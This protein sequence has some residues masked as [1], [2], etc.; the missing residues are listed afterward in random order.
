MHF[1][2]KVYNIIIN[3]IDFAKQINTQTNTKRENNQHALE[4]SSGLSGLG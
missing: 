1:S 2:L 3:T 4:E